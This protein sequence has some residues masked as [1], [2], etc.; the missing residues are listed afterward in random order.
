MRKTA[1]IDILQ[2]NKLI[3]PEP[4]IMELDKKESLG[5][6]FRKHYIDYIKSILEDEELSNFYYPLSSLSIRISYLEDSRNSYYMKTS[7][8]QLNGIREINELFEE[9]I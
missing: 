4:F 3:S 7:V 8:I 1:F 2:E 5:K 9:V 6:S